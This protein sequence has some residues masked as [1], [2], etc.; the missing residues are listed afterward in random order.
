MLILVALML[1][2]IVMYTAKNCE[3]LCKEISFS[4][5]FS[6]STTTQ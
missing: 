4:K 3:T 2:P 5:A 1:V 6:M